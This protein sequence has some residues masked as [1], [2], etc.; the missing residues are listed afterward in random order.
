M[1]TQNTQPDY[2]DV[3]KI[4]NENIDKIIT[5]IDTAQ[6]EYINLN[7]ELETLKKNITDLINH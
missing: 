3:L 1:T 6:K 5:N 2:C 7:N 4:T